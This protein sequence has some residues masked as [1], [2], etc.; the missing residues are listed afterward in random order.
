[1]KLVVKLLSTTVLIFSTS[2]AYG[3]LLTVNP[4]PGDVD[5]SESLTLPVGAYWSNP[6]PAQLSGH[7]GGVSRSPFDGSGA[8]PDYG[9]DNAI[10]H[11]SLGTHALNNTTMS[12]LNFAADQ[13]SLTLAWGSPDT[14]NYL[15]FYSDNTLV[16]S[17]NGSQVIN[18]GAQRGVSL[19]WVTASDM[20]FD[21]VKFIS[22]RNAFEFA[23]VSSTPVPAPASL[24]LLLAGVA[25]VGLRRRL[26]KD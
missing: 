16:G 11:W 15:E 3:L 22:T 14:Y 18:A 10:V 19:A 23:N 7:I 21:Q 5:T 20:V 2:F 26:F 13:S 8:S 24:A 25:M 6:A 9:D 1:M 12:W 17:V 4:N